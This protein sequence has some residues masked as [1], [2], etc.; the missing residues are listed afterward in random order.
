[1]TPSAPP[2]SSAPAGGDGAAPAVSAKSIVLT[3]G[4]G[5]VG[6]VLRRALAGRIAAV[7]IV[8]VVDP[9]ELAGHESWTPADITDLA[10][11]TAEALAQISD[12]TGFVLHGSSDAERVADTNDTWE[13]EEEK[14]VEVVP[15]PPAVAKKY[16]V[17]E[18]AERINGALF[19]W[20]WKSGTG[21]HWK[22]A[23]ALGGASVLGGALQN[24]NWQLAPDPLPAMQMEVASGGRV[25]RTAGID[26]P[27]GFPDKAFSVPA[28]SKVTLLIDNSHLTT[29]YPE[30]TVSG[31]RDARIRLTYA[32]ALFDAMRRQEG[33]A[34]NDAVVTTG[35]G[36]LLARE[37]NPS[38]E[39][40]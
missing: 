5:N 40:E 1:V 38:T 10:V 36:L 37:T 22:K 26:I 13:V 21:G 32:E 9:G 7:R 34:A 8:D 2:G 18:P 31:G 35:A 14:G 19:D 6:R 24:D 17:S 27:N 23:K 3:G 4:S 20:E 12:R 16:Y 30:L 33:I 28:H 11:L 15:T 29:A 25:V 39:A